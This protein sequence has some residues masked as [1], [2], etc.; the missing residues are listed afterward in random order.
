MVP[1]EHV[2][3]NLSGILS[4]SKKTMNFGTKTHDYGVKS[5]LEISLCP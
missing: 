2:L 4:N 5:A 3:L 1:I